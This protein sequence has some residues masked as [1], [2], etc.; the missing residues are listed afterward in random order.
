MG[1]P[2][3][4]DFLKGLEGRLEG[5]VP[6]RSPGSVV[7]L[8]V[9]DSISRTKGKEAGKEGRGKKVQPLASVGP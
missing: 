8:M 6:L 3:R 9:L 2:A 5:N 4:E 7:V 1:E